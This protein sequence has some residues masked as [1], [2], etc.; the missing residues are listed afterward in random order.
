MDGDTTSARLVLCE[1]LS[2]ESALTEH[3]LS[4]RTLLPVER[5]RRGLAGLE[6]WGILEVTE[7]ARGEATPHYSVAAGSVDA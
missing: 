2:A 3:H 1:L 5:V 6:T 4:E 7:P